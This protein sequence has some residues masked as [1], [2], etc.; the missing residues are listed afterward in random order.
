MKNMFLIPN[1]FKLIGLAIFILFA[2]IGLGSMYLEI[3]PSF[4]KFSVGNCDGQDGLDCAEVNFLNTIA[5]A[6]TIIG[7]LLISFSKEKSEDE[8]ISFLRL[9]SWQWSVLIS[10]TILIILNFCVYSTPFLAVMLYNMFT[11]LIV[12]IIK[13]NYSMYSLR[14]EG[15]ND[16]K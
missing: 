9:K 7:L 2:L 10:Y 4:F 16:E 8:Y 15:G 6:G 12:F 13:F 14:K 5:F 3:A 1:R 11:V